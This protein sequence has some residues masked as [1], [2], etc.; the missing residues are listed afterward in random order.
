MNRLGAKRLKELELETFPTNNHAHYMP[1]PPDDQETG[2]KNLG[3]LI[4]SC[5][6][7]KH[8]ILDEKK[9]FFQIGKGGISLNKSQTSKYFEILDL[10]STDDDGSPS[11]LSRA[12]TDTMIQECM[13]NA[14][15]DKTKGIGSDLE[16]RIE[17]A[18]NDLRKN[19]A[20]PEKDWEVWQL[21]DH[22][23]VSDE[24]F[25]FGNVFFC[26]GDHPAAQ[27]LQPE[28]SKW[29]K[30]IS[31]IVMGQISVRA[32][33]FIA[34]KRRA[35]VE[36]QKTFDVLNFFAEIVSLP[37]RLPVV[38]IH[39]SWN[40]FEYL[41]FAIAADGHNPH[42][43][44]QFLRNCDAFDP[45]TFHCGHN[46][47]IL[48]A[49]RKASDLFSRKTKYA[50]RLVKSMK[51]AGKAAAS[52][53]RENRYLLY[54][55]ALESLLFGKWESREFAKILSK[56]IFKIL[57]ISQEDRSKG[58][59]IIDRLHKL[60]CALVHSGKTEIPDVDLAFVREMTIEC[61]IGLICDETIEHTPTDAL[62]AWFNLPDEKSNTN[63]K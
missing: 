38:S 22:L 3:H 30:S 55:I 33:D 43:S 5:A 47:E 13:L 40:R 31:K 57:Q 60:R 2:L 48:T 17:V 45:L 36:F 9:F 37:D 8:D 61:I 49:F 26:V 1:K 23:T 59:E 25:T 20:R 15:H 6:R 28:V 21:V 32:V 56:R 34:A 4:K 29:K 42:V 7:P 35:K 24:G 44:Q 14:V 10:L 51:W 39:E 11:H 16:C 52:E 19:L 50:E 12:A 27:K 63:P 58:F 53:T 46:P 62:E 18:I 41:Q 54:F